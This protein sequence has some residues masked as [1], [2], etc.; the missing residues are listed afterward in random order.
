[1]VSFTPRP[2]YAQGKSPWHPLDRR[3]GGP[4]ILLGKQEFPKK[5]IVQ[6]ILNINK[7]HIV[8]N[9]W[10]KRCRAEGIPSRRNEENKKKKLK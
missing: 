5:Y 4:Q 10:D 1:V 2:L 8:G 7:L 3:L 9:V 6:G